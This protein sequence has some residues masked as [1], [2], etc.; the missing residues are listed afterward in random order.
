MPNAQQ[1]AARLRRAER[2]QRIVSLLRDGL[3]TFDVAGILAS[4]GTP[5]TRSMVSRIRMKHERALMQETKRDV[6][7]MRYRL[8]EQYRKARREL[9]AAWERSQR[10]KAKSKRKSI[11]M[12]AAEGS[13]RVVDQTIL[14]ENT[15]EGRDGNPAFLVALMKAIEGEAVLLGLQNEPIQPGEDTLTDS[16]AKLQRAAEII[17]LAQSRRLAAL[18]PAQGVIDVGEGAPA[19]EG[20][21]DVSRSGALE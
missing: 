10:P 2:D 19:V 4:E 9:W 18:T 6:E 16:A 3:S 12:P 21:T 20:G 8:I 5:I 1:S 17:Q 7:H 11:P 15:V 14:N 13:N